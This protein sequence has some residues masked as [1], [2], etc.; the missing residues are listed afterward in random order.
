MEFLKE[1]KLTFRI[2]RYGYR[3][4]IAYDDER[5]EFAHDSPVY[6]SR[7]DGN[8]K[9]R[10][11]PPQRQQVSKGYRASNRGIA[12]TPR[13]MQISDVCYYIRQSARRI[14]I[15]QGHL[16]AHSATRESIMCVA[17]KISVARS[18]RRHVYFDAP[19]I[20]HSTF[21]HS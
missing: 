9:L 8:Q 10:Y 12:I 17:C 2:V 4:G 15:R 11:E 14:S 16:L 18:I 19:F 1:R 21:P 7:I 20:F 5:R 3:A 6:R 13:R